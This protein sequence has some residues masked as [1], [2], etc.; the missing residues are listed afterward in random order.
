MRIPAKFAFSWKYTSYVILGALG[1]VENG[2]DSKLAM[3]RMWMEGKDS[4]EG[5][6]RVQGERGEEASGEVEAVV[7]G[8]IYTQ[9]KTIERRCLYVISGLG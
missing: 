5:R 6:R 1:F 3:A 8:T 4:C 7:A 9:G 2:G